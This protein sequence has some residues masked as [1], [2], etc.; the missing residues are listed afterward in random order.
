MHKDCNFKELASSW[1]LRKDIE[2]YLCARMIR[3]FAWAAAS[4][5]SS[6]P[7]GEPLFEH[8]EKPHLVVSR[9]V[10]PCGPGWTVP[11][12]RDGANP[13]LRRPGRAN[14][15]VTVRPTKA[16][17]AMATTPRSS[18]HWTSWKWSTSGQSRKIS[19]QS[20]REMVSINTRGRQLKKVCIWKTVKRFRPK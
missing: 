11:D 15:L 16:V 10:T 3:F 12:H 19:H 5:S 8:T 4:S 7:R 1:T 13:D 2:I 6:T 18:G 17:M 14:D 9:R 20:C